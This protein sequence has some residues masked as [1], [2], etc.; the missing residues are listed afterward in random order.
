M[1][2]EPGSHSFPFKSIFEWHRSYVMYYFKHFSK[3]YGILFNTFYLIIDSKLIYSEIN[4]LVRDK[5]SKFYIDNVILFTLI[6]LLISTMLSWISIKIAPNIGLMDIPSADHKVIK[7]NTSYWWPCF[8]K[9]NHY[10]GIL[11]RVME[12]S[13]N[14]RCASVWNIHCNFWS[15]R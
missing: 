6:S 7:T 12:K 15:D 14:F 5:C 9:H 8:N 2:E 1:K 3:D 11:Y 4:F 10:H 13:K